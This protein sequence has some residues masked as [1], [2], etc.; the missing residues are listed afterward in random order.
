[1][2]AP[3]VLGRSVVAAPDAAFFSEWRKA[4]A[5]REAG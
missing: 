2:F 5:E 1:L 4:I 3:G